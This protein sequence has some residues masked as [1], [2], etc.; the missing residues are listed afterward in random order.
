MTEAQVADRMG[1]HYPEEW[2]AFVGDLLELHGAGDR[3]RGSL[4][5][6]RRSLQAAL[7][8]HNYQGKAILWWLR[9]RGPPWMEYVT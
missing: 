5:R 4:M 2:R 3:T 6:L 1:L 7:Q 9:R 8:D